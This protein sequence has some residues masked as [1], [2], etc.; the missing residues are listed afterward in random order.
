MNTPKTFQLAWT[1]RVPALA[2]ALAPLAAP[3][4]VV[5][6]ENLSGESSSYPWSALGGACLTARTSGSAGTS[7]IPGCIGLPAYAARHP[8]SGRTATD[9]W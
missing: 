9:E 6:V 5:I 1:F 2:L 8:R 7:T 3:A 4:Q